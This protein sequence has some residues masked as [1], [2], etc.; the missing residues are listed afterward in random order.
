MKS[1][2]YSQFVGIDRT[3]NPVDAP[4]VAFVKLDNAVVDSTTGAVTM[5]GGSTEWSATG[6]ILGIFGYS[7]ESASYL[8]PNVS[9]VV[10]H[11]RNGSTSYIERLDWSNSTWT[12]ITQGANT[13]FGASG[14]AQSAQIDDVLCVCAGRPAYINDVT[15]GNINR[16]GGPAPTAAPTLGLS[17]TGL[18]GFTRAFYTFYN[19]TTGWE[20]S[21]SPIA[22]ITAT[23]DQIDWS[24]LEITCAKE[25]VDKKNLYRTELLT[26]G[27]GTFKRV[28]QINLATTTY[29]D[30]VADASLGVDA[31]A[32]GDHEPP[33]STSYICIAYANKFWIASGNELFYSKTYDGTLK[34]LE[35]FSLDRVFRFPAR[36]TGLAYTPDFGK[37][38]IFLPSGLGIHYL[39]GRSDDTFEQDI[40]KA[41]E[42]TNFPASVSWHDEHVAYWGARGPQLINTGGVVRDFAGGLSGQLSGIVE[43]EYNS[44][45]YI[46]SEWS[47]YYEQFLFGISATD[48]ATSQWFDRVTNLPVGWINRTTGAL[49]EW[50]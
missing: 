40:F 36:I 28:A 49:V 9:H 18:T 31:P 50:Q 20:S 33:P 48:T 46:F 24:A 1:E 11:R 42:G 5:R 45:V 8:V 2:H 27:A 12:A 35:Y 17:G 25:G 10:R 39:S 19:S 23:N 16:L 21:P 7:K 15:A 38:L 37:L 32:V 34:S 41:R 29:S 14:I 13:S 6:D 4:Q 22:E 3:T 30:T 26:E 47:A 44:T 43:K